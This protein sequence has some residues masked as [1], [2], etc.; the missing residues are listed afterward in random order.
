MYQTNV[1]Q[2]GNTLINKIPILKKMQYKLH[3]ITSF[4][5]DPLFTIEKK[6]LKTI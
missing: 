2:R 5:S 6:K 1:P 4:T 3:E